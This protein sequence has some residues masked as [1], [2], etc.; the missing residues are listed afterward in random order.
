MTLVRSPFKKR[1]TIAGSSLDDSKKSTP[2]GTP[3]SLRSETGRRASTGTASS[4]NSFFEDSDDT[5][6]CLVVCEPINSDNN[7]IASN[8]EPDIP[9]VPRNS[10]EIPSP[11][12]ILKVPL[13]NECQDFE[14]CM[15][16]D[17]P[18]TPV[19]IN[20]SKN[21]LLEMDGKPDIKSSIDCHLDQIDRVNKNLDKILEAHHQIMLETKESAT[22]Y[23]QIESHETIQDRIRFKDKIADK[24]KVLKESRLVHMS[25]DDIKNRIKKIN[26]F[27]KQSSQDDGETSGDVEE[28][29]EEPGS[30]VKSKRK[31]LKLSKSLFSSFRE[32]KRDQA[33]PGP[34]STPTP[35]IEEE[36][37][38][39]GNENYGRLIQTTDLD[40][41]EEEDE[42]SGSFG[43]SSGKARKMKTKLREN[44]HKLNLKLSKNKFFG[45]KSVNLEEELE[46]C[47]KC[48]KRRNSL[49][50]TK[51]HP[52][53]AVLDFNKEF[54]VDSLL[55]EMDLCIC[56]E[57][58]ETDDGEVLII[59]KHD[60]G[61]ASAS[62]SIFCGVFG[63]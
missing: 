31:A 49:Q 20:S 34:S 61:N 8:S 40:A 47:K 24:L 35:E 46:I 63:F 50:D 28:I 55:T 7:A 41:E 4:V 57:D 54:H 23:E 32:K 36:F 56:E 51:I 26:V 5:N 15:E 9:E 25:S 60:P 10:P 16:V 38:E 45:K 29:T 37:E 12:E 39:V 43:E 42:S 53:K 52:S 1:Q 58:D 6:K 62:V 22:K 59:K 18:P 21:S 30:A 3:K 44:L 27:K 48:S 13:I 2:N 14:E 33:S 19:E 17:T 11:I